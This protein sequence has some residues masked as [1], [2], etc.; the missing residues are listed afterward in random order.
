MPQPNAVAWNLATIA[1]FWFTG[2]PSHA[3]L[4]T[5]QMRQLL[6]LERFQMEVQRA[7]QNV[8]QAATKR[9]REFWDDMAEK[10]ERLVAYAVAQE[11][12]EAEVESR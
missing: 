6:A 1:E 3:L 2:S 9:D 4:G 11:T 7:R 8:K 5:E 12:R 10:W